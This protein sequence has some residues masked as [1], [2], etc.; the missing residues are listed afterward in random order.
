MTKIIEL[1]L[2]VETKNKPMRSDIGF[3]G[4][5]RFY[6]DKNNNASVEC[7][8]FISAY[9]K[10]MYYDDGWISDYIDEAKSEYLGDTL[11]FIDLMLE[12]DPEFKVWENFDEED[13]FIIS[14]VGFFEEKTGTDGDWENGYYT[15]VVFIPKIAGYEIVKKEHKQAIYNGADDYE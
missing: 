7:I 6:K 15:T 8:D 13:E 11:E 3:E 1:K 4:F 9:T 14:V 12:Y 5:Y 2:S 10:T